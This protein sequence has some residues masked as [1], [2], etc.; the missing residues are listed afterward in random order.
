MGAGRARRFH[1][2]RIGIAVA[3]T[4]VLLAA[5]QPGIAGQARVKVSMLVFAGANQEVVPREGFEAAIR[6]RQ[7]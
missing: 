2:P 1:S 6:R 3:L 7:K 4:A 5:L